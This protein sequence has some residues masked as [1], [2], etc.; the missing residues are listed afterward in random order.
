MNCERF[1]II[2]TFLKTIEILRLHFLKIF[3]TNKIFSFLVIF[4]ARNRH[5]TMIEDYI[6]KDDVIWWK[7]DHLIFIEIE[8]RLHF[9]KLVVQTKNFFLTC[10][11]YA[12]STFN[13]DRKLY[14][15]KWC[16]QI[17]TWFNSHWKI[18]SLFSFH[19][20]LSRKILCWNDNYSIFKATRNWTNLSLMNDFVKSSIIIWSINT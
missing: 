5:S 2:L 13:N 14:K 3:F 18:D 12:K 15:K 7:L 1:F 11:V 16:D 9:L 20:L 10:S 17:R 4:C 6:K 19:R 8:S